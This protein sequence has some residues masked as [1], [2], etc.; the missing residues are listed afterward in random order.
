MNSIRK[1]LTIGMLSI[2]LLVTTL[3][4]CVSTA[5]EEPDCDAAFRTCLVHAGLIAAG[6]PVAGTAYVAFCLNG[7]VFCLKY[8]S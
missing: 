2:L 8:V 4:P 5:A 6:N 1:N 3:I 7:Y